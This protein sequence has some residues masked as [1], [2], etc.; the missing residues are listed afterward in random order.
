VVRT[1]LLEHAPFCGRRVEQVSIEPF[2][3][4]LPGGCLLFFSTAGLRWFYDVDGVAVTR[5]RVWP[6][7]PVS[8]ARETLLGWPLSKNIRSKDGPID[9]ISRSRVL[10]EL[11]GGGGGEGGRLQILIE[12]LTPC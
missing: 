6:M 1:A 12:K 3:I 9:F 4:V 8:Q 7:L 11:M 5:C 10:A 2:Y